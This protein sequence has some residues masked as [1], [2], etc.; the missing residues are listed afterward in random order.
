[1][2]S[3]HLKLLGSTALLCSLVAGTNFAHANGDEAPVI[4]TPTQ[5]N[6]AP[7][8]MSKSGIQHGPYIGVAAGLRLDRHEVTMS[9]DNADGIAGATPVGAFRNFAAEDQSFTGGV[10][11]GYGVRFAEHFYASL[12]A[13]VLFGNM[14]DDSSFV[15]DDDTRGRAD[16]KIK[17]KTRFGLAARLGGYWKQTLLYAR[18]GV[19][20]QRFEI[21][22]SSDAVRLNDPTRSDIPLSK[23]YTKAAFTPGVGIEVSLNDEVSLGL[24]YRTAL[25]SKKTET[26]PSN[27]ADI[28]STFVKHRPR[29][30]SVLIRVNYKLINFSA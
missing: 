3:Y 18:F 23:K 7:A 26:A 12:E 1:M 30:D 2:K 15:V 27:Q 17:G 19:E 11:L 6:P 28:S 16:S 4:V 21:N 29:V 9:N 14:S 22:S 13:D 8:P 20:W 24:E 10:Q 25:F 5:S